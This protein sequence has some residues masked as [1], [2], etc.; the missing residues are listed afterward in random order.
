MVIY[1]LVWLLGNLGRTQS[2]LQGPSGVVV[3]PRLSPG[4]WSFHCV[5]WGRWWGRLTGKT[6]SQ[7][8]AAVMT[9]C[10]APPAPAAPTKAEAQ[11]LSCSLPWSLGS[12]DVLHGATGC[13]E[14]SDLYQLCQHPP[15]PGMAYPK[16]LPSF[17]P[18]L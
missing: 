6:L 14:G 16:P 13:W 4:L 5:F 12:W 11:R 7:T 3:C 1:Y 18:H 9:H 10:L 15:E 17:Q 8:P 2:L